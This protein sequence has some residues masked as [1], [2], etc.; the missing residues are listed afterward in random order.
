MRAEH[1]KRRAEQEQ[2]FLQIAER[3]ACTMGT[4]AEDI[5]TL[6]LSSITVIV[7]KLVCHGLVERERCE[8]DRRVVK[9]K[10]SEEGARIYTSYTEM[11]KQTCKKML[12][13]LTIAEQDSLIQIYHKLLEH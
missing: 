10:L 3:G 12:A 8:N 4:L 2:L 6:S 7:D 5:G 13:R 11:L 9:A 1:I